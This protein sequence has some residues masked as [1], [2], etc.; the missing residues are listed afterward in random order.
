MAAQLLST[1]GE[2]RLSVED[3]FHRRLAAWFLQTRASLTCT[4]LALHAG[5]TPPRSAA[6]DD[7]LRVVGVIKYSETSH[8]V[9]V[10][11]TVLAG[12]DFMVGLITYGNGC[13][14]AGETIFLV[15]GDTAEITPYD[16]DRTRTSDFCMQAQRYLAHTATLKFHRAGQAT[17]QVRGR[18]SPPDTLVTLRYTVRVR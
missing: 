8:P 6:A 14:T 9:S 10:P 12:V 11:D 17:V 4:A 3:R 1:R 15:S 7:A 18:H 2:P 16:Y 5:C 13:V